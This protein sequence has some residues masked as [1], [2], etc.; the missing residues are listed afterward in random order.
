[1][2]KYRCFSDNGSQ[3][4]NLLTFSFPGRK[5]PWYLDLGNGRQ[6]GFLKFAS[7]MYFFCD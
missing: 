2:G 5:M 3:L 7:E 4:R 6:H 1:M